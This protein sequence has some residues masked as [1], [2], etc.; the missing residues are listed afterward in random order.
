MTRVL[1][2]LML[3]RVTP[4]ANGDTVIMIGCVL[5]LIS[6]SLSLSVGS[7]A[8][9]N[10]H[11]CSFFL[12]VGDPTVA[13]YMHPDDSVAYPA[14]PPPNVL[15]L[16]LATLSANWPAG[17]PAP[18][19][20]ANQQFGSRIF[21]RD[22]HPDFWTE[23]QLAAQDPIATA[24]PNGTVLTGNAGAGKVWQSNSMRAPI[25]GLLHPVV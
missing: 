5:I 3:V 10:P 8:L 20:F 4:A 15:Q 21:M 7:P 22:M 2:L 6:L 11:W 17:L 23:L 13:V 16:H 25:E 18:A 12:A 14:N 19:L 24:I 9:S 1:A